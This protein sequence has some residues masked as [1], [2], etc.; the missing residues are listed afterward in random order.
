[1]F[2]IS[3]R[4][5]VATGRVER[6]VIHAGESVEIV[7]FSPFAMPAQVLDL[8]RLRPEATAA[9]PGDRIGAVLGAVQGSDVQG[10]QVLAAPGSIRAHDRFKA[11]I[12]VLRKEEGGRH[13]PFFN[14][15]RPQFFFRTTDVTGEIILPEGR[16]L[17]LPGDHVTVDVELIT[18]VAMEQQLRFAIRDPKRAVGVGVVVETIH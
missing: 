12:Y 14:H 10:G 13:A 1:V 8:L 4:G 9:M 18:P 16:E 2:S 6:G 7:G 3:G 17:V 15:Y 5:T 11:E